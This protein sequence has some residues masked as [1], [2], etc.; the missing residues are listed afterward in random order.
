MILNT[1]IKITR[2][3]VISGECHFLMELSVCLFYYYTPFLLRSFPKIA[4]IGESKWKLTS[5]SWF[6]YQIILERIR[7]QLTK[8]Q[9]DFQGFWW[10]S[11]CV[12]NFK[13]DCS[14][15]CTHS[16]LSK[17]RCGARHESGLRKARAAG[18]W[19]KQEAIRWS[20]WRSTSPLT[21]RWCWMKVGCRAHAATRAHKHA[22]RLLPVLGP[23]KLCL[24]ALQPHRFTRVGV[25]LGVCCANV[26]LLN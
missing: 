13:E 18:R 22:S 1:D 24:T 15:F 17:L 19:R 2:R 3:T 12:Q 16:I 10:L 9:R 6:N 26:P 7:G 5:F 23:H 4:H 21:S 25:R 20:I 11:H 14:N 8:F